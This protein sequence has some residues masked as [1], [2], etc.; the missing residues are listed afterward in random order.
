MYYIIPKNQSCF[1]MTHCNLSDSFSRFTSSNHHLMC[2]TESNQTSTLSLE[3]LA[4]WSALVLLIFYC[5]Q[6]VTLAIGLDPSTQPFTESAPISETTLWINL[7]IIVSSIAASAVTLTISRHT[8][9]R[10]FGTLALHWKT[11]SWMLS[12]V[13]LSVVLNLLGNQLLELLQ[14][15]P[16]ANFSRY[17]HTG[18]QYLLTWLAVGLAAPIFEELFFRGFVYT[19]LITYRYGLLAALLIP[20]L[21]WCLMHLSQYDL[22]GLTVLFAMGVIFTLIRW[23]SGHIIYP[24]LMHSAFN[25]TTLVVASSQ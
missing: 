25:L 2:P 16:E 20:N 9:F 18:H 3:S 21:V 23:L 10:L 6:L 4:A 17:L 12:I 1:E 24:L 19:H 14:W 11:W 15:Q 13:L 8:K 7:A 22:I 5:A